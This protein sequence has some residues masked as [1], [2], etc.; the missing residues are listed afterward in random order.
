MKKHYIIPKI[1]CLKMLETE[2]LVG[3]DGDRKVE[4]EVENPPEFDPNEPAGPPE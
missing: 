3:S 4:G 1:T 2:I